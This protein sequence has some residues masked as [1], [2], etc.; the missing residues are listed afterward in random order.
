MVRRRRA[1]TVRLPEYNKV[2]IDDITLRKSHGYLGGTLGRLGR[3]DRLVYD[4]FADCHR[5]VTAIPARNGFRNYFTARGGPVRSSPS[6]PLT[7]PR[8]SHPIDLA[9]VH[10]LPL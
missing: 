7:A 6:P 4:A 8:T 10:C 1:Q 9:R 2:P 5:L 3:R